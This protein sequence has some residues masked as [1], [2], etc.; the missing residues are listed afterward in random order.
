MNSCLACPIHIIKKRICNN[1]YTYHDLCFKFLQENH[2]NSASEFDQYF[3]LGHNIVIL[4]RDI[5]VL[6]EGISG[7]TLKKLL[8]LEPARDPYHN[9]LARWSS[10]P[11]DYPRCGLQWFLQFWIVLF[12]CFVC[13]LDSSKWQLDLLWETHYECIK[14]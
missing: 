2:L 9:E 12:A 6:K 7:W 10:F 11:R 5:Y 1:W 4:L 13:A 8:D 3:V 14:L